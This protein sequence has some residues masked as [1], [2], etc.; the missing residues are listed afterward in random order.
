[1]LTYKSLDFNQIVNINHNANLHPPLQ[2]QQEAQVIV[3]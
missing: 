2:H 1:M 3:W